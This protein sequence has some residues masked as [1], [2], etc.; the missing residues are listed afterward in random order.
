MLLDMS[1]L[2]GS[3]ID[4]LQTFAGDRRLFADYRVILITSQRPKAPKEL[5]NTVTSNDIPVVSRPLDFDTLL[6]HIAQAYAE[7]GAGD[8][9]LNG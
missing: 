5:I 2:Q 3:A 6:T 9:A 8:K 1:A 7:L 4:L